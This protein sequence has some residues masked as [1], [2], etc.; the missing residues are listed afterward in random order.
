[1]H[2]KDDS[3][4]ALVLV[5]GKPSDAVAASVAA[6]LRGSFE[7][8]SVAVESVAELRETVEHYRDRLGDRLGALVVGAADATAASTLV[9]DLDR[10]MRW[11]SERTLVVVDA[12][13][14]L[15]EV[16]ARLLEALPYR[17]VSEGALDD[18]AELVELL[19]DRRPK[20]DV[21]ASLVRT[22]VERR[23]IDSVPPLLGDWTSA[24]TLAPE[25]LVLA[26][27]GDGGR[28]PNPLWAQWSAQRDAAAIDRLGARV[29]AHERWLA[30]ANSKVWRALPQPAPVDAPSQSVQE[31]VPQK[32]HGRRK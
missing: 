17:A 2:A 21:L 16:P 31:V 22:A 7:T 10:G 8:V 27:D 5:V 28:R 32:K 25:R 14:T 19:V 29:D 26:H 1:M 3:G 9:W 4:S 6:R 12:L 11:L 24:D 18:L 23:N 30:R 15:D 13:A 20:L